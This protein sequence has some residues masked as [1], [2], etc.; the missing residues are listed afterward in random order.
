M[1]PNFPTFKRLSIKDK[2][3]IDALVHQFPP[4][5]DFNFTSLLS[6]DFDKGTS[7]S[8]LHNN[9]VVKLY[10]YID[11][12]PL[13]TLL[14]KHNLTQACEDVL[15][16]AVTHNM[17]AQL[18]MIPEVVV[19]ALK[20]DLKKHKVSF[21]CK[22]DEGNFDYIYNI[23]HIL[24]LKGTPYRIKR[25]S[26]K[27]FRESHEE[28][29][30]L[31]LLDPTSPDIVK[32][33]VHVFRDWGTMKNQSR[34][35]I[36]NEFAA[37]K[38]L[39]KYAKGLPVNILGMFVDDKLSGFIVCEALPDKYGALHFGKTNLHATGA[40][41]YLIYKSAELLHSQGCEYLNLQQDLSIENLRH[42]KLSWRPTTFLKK[43]TVSPAKPHS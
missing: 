11:K 24:N 42:T 16:Y 13:I 17:P 29:T 32:Q 28:R 37:F 39:L 25:K 22:K 5:S 35:Y 43:Y 27:R 9:L 4:Y 18:S 2:K 36:R 6:W 19:H 30:R 26:I 12:R 7:V 10:D 40:F 14:G 21:R 38:R 3:E 15:A 1:L 8:L 20:K 34:S 41:E 31:A 33:L 23:Q